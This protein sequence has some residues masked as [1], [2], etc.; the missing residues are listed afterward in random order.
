[1]RVGLC[2][3]LR[4]TY[5]AMGY[6][7]EET[8]EF[9]KAD[10]I[11]GIANALQTLGFDVEKIGHAKQLIS[12]LNNNCRW[13]IVFSICE[14]MFGTGREAQVPSILDVFKIPYVFSAPHVLSLS[15]H[16]ALTKRVVR[17]AGISTPDFFVVEHPDDIR[18]ITLPLPLFVKP[19]AEGTGKG[20]SG[21]S[22]VRDKNK[23]DGICRYL[24]G[25]YP[26]GVLVERLLP[27]R[28]FT[29]GITG[30]GRDSRAVG[31]MEIIY[32]SSS[33]DAVYSYETKENYQ[34]KVHYHIPEK[35]IS[36]ACEKLS[37]EV[38]KVLGCYDGG[39][40]DVKLDENN[41]PSFMEVNPLAGLN[42]VHSDLP[43]LARKHG[44]GYNQLISMIMDSAI[45]RLNLIG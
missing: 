1:M 14:G 4:E 28:E 7:E 8:A 43:I 30:T 12:L 22:I 34:T 39:R 5:L 26:Q 29:V 42:P 31:T 3:D 41:I 32:G 6:S 21:N 20:I 23:L 18:K 40:V 16:K 13:D 11:D 35:E 33:D 36:I 2:Y 17:D 25:I 37:L 19:V 9:D 38:W 15:L 24:L 27:G 45:K 10:T 44:I